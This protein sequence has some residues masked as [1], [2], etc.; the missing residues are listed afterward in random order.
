MRRFAIKTPSFLF[1]FL[2]IFLAFQGCK[3]KG[4]DAL[5]QQI[6]DAVSAY[7]YAYSSG[8]IS[9]ASSI[10]VRFTNTI[11][12]NS[13]VPKNFISF[14]PAISGTA[15]WEDSQT[16]SFTPDEALP[17]GQAYIATV[18]L[19]SVFSDVPS[20]AKSF[21]FDFRTKDQ[22]FEIDIAGLQAPNP[23][24]LTEQEIVGQLLSTD[25]LESEKV[26]PL[27]AATQVGKSLDI[28]WTHSS[29]G[30]TH[31]F[32]IKG[33]SRSKQ[34]SAVN[35]NWTG[36]SIGLETKGKRQYEIPALGDFKL[37]DVKVIQTPE[38][39][40][41]LTFSDPLDENQN[42]NGLITLSNYTGNFR[43]IIDGAQIRAYPSRR[44]VGTQALRIERGIKNIAKDKM[45]KLSTY[46]VS[47]ED[48]KPQVRL[49]GNG[50]ILPESE[51]L[52]FPFEAIALNAVEVEVFKIFN[53]NIL[54]FLQS[55]ELSGNYDLQRVG[56]VVLQEKVKLSDLNPIA[57]PTDWTRY[58][59][60]L[61][62]MIEQDPEAIYQI[63]IGFRP[64]YTTYFCENDEQNGTDDL[65]VV[66]D[67]FDND[68]NIKSIMNSWYG[69]NG[70]YPSYNWRQRE[71]P[72]Y[73]AYYNSD[74]F[75]QR[76]VIASNLGII[77]KGGKDNNFFVCVSD[78]RTTAPIANATIN[79]YDY[80]QQLLQTATTNAEG[81]AQIQA[82]RTP[83]ILVAQKDQEKGYLKL[84]DGNAL[85]LSRFDVSGS[86]TQKGL[87][88]FLYADRGVW[89]PGDSIYLNFILEDKEGKL[90]TNYPISMEVLNPRGQVYTKRSTSKHTNGVYPLHFATNVDDPTGN[91][92]VNIKAGG[93]FF[94]KTLK[95]ETVKPNRLKIDLDF[96]QEELS[97][98]DEPITADL[99]VNWLHG[100]AASNLKTV[101]EMQLS[102]VNT[103]FAK[104]DDFEFDDPARRFESGEPKTIF[105]QEVSGSGSATVLTRIA[106]NRKMPGKLSAKF[107]TRAF[108][109]GGDFSTDNFKVMYHPYEDY[110]GVAIPKNKYNQNRI[111][112]KETGTIDFVSVDMDGQPQSGKQLKIGLYRVNWRWW[113]ERGY[114]NISRYNSSSHYDALETTTVTTN[115]KGLA[116]WK[117]KVDNWGRYMI[118]VCDEES[119]HCS[120]D[121]FYAGY[122]WYGKDGNRDA[123]AMLAFSADKQNY[124]VGQDVEL[125]IPASESGRALITIENGT[126]VVE[127]FWTNTE[128]GENS[129]TFK[130]TPEMSP[131]VYA[132]VS[133]VQA[134]A[135][136]ENDLPIR[137]YGVIPI[138]VEDPETHLAPAIAMPDVLAPEE[139]ITVEVSEDNG[140][141]MAYTIAMVDE[142]L[143]GLTRFKTPN[144]WNTFYAREALG[145]RTW[146]V[147]DKVLGAYGGELERILSIGGDDEAVGNGD[148]KRANRFKPVVKHLGPFYLKKG[149][150]AK[151]QIEIPNY[152]G[153][154]R[155]MV[156][157]A[158]KGAYGS[159]DK[160]T[161]VRKPL[162]VLAT[163]PRVLGPNE[164]LQLPVNVFAM[165][166]KI[167]NVKVSIKESTGLIDLRESSKNIRFSK[168]GDQIVSFDIAVKEYV[169]VAKFT[170]I[171]E[172]NGEKATQEIE[173]DVR[174][175][176]P[177]MTKSENKVVSGGESWNYDFNPFG[178]AGTNEAILE[179]SSIPPINLGERLQYLIRY[180]YGCIEQ[181]LSGGFPQLYVDKLL[182]L[183]EDQKRQVPENVQATIDRLRLFQVD[184]GGFSYWPGHTAPNHYASNYAGHFL[185]AAKEKGYSVSSNMIDRWAAFQKKVA[186]MWNNEKEARAY[187]FYT[188]SSNQLG[189]AYRLYTLAL[190]KKPDMASMNRMRELKDLSPQAKWRL[191]AA[192][193]ES[194]KPEVAK[195]I[196]KGV[197]NDFPTY[198]ELSG[199]FGSRLRDR[200]MVLETL[201]LLKNEEEAANIVKYISD[202]LSSS[203]WLNTQSIAYSLLAIGK[204]VGDSD[205]DDLK[206]AYSVDGGRTVNTASDRPMIQIP[207]EI[208]RNESHKF[209]VKNS[210]NSKLFARLVQIGQAI[211]G[212]EEASSSN[213]EINVRY[214]DLK[215]I[216]IDPSEIAQGT[217]FI[218]EVQIIHPGLRPMR[219]D[220]MALAQIFPSG[221]E[222]LNTRMDGIQNF[223]AASPSEY[224]DFRDDRVHTFF[225]LPES[226][227]YVYRVQ[228]NAAYQGRFYLPA[229]NC[230]A[231]YDNS[232]SA[233]TT[234]R[235]V[236]VSA[237]KEF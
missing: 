9:R 21:K 162:M 44:I 35:L 97:I 218:A 46:D 41:R 229:V 53:N 52:I 190:A 232:I 113:W 69:I 109:K 122:P 16:L 231:M 120:G 186:R 146:D 127:S 38:Q 88:G 17:S 29:D 93:A 57:A 184:N 194:G 204:Y 108:E 63:R 100:A 151:H 150:K 134:H 191:A 152:V 179:V 208:K 215:G 140:K 187:G 55:N 26:A 210:G 181:T 223:K 28:E 171:A 170:I 70:Y 143:L 87:K 195:Q 115:S 114:D 205:I 51:G 189:Q 182:D 196:I 237:P 125:K 95:I 49:V 169:G 77:A 94:N 213:L 1:A 157:A 65:T 24:K 224:Q 90:P 56:R 209:M 12:P 40:V 174:N 48:I 168:V 233:N 234:G 10:K 124:N 212:A 83:F 172:G 73:G 221:W 33:I 139:T 158:D 104:Y 15:V 129:F 220:E 78:L 118:R 148:D 72:C 132:H 7:V 117:I 163:L 31:E 226:S 164:S 2:A 228:L 13:E 119:G 86:Y 6:S 192:Y 25:M 107:K 60:D 71:D 141:A 96:G 126:K 144:P 92:S 91:W 161:P 167:K 85:S 175:P 173:I 62:Q 20:E 200:A 75:V 84:G 82:E 59:L 227:S 236:E 98:K 235:W 27:L 103:T 89:R 207:I 159:T 23:K 54:Q 177:Y 176:N 36:K 4:Q 58:A 147:Y 68:G 222:I 154:V 217:D 123:A 66:E 136:K 18:K 42:L 206:F 137:M 138:S 165:E 128:K 180:P 193:A 216:V 8:T 155:T 79:F 105:D 102:S 34:A 43:F 116:E 64:S 178:M 219:Y 45:Q 39:Y 153:A 14:Q 133:L 156:V 145:V 106:N 110:T 37:T 203:S 74:R 230:E 50:V 166:D 201:I 199:T 47:F 76:N 142:G 121:F 198:Q 3:N 111:E 30:L 188:R 211:T 112:I 197:S 149:Q 185:L 67:T 81:I 225:D 11:N 135:Q 183:T 19:K 130:T 22:Y 160:T 5:N 80:Q 202:E 32:V 214:K 99:Q 61:S 131:T 101:V